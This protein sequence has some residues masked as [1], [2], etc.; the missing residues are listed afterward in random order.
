[1]SDENDGPE[2]LRGYEIGYRRPPK[3]TRFKPGQS[4]NKKGRPRKK[5][6]V[7]QMIE[8][9]LAKLIQ[10]DENGR[11]RLMTAEEII[12]SKL[13]NDAMKGDLR[14]IRMLFDMRDRYQNSLETEIDPAALKDDQDILNEYLLRAKDGFG[15]C[16]AADVEGGHETELRS[17]ENRSAGR[18]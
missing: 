11:R 5:T 8:N 3:H 6:P 7:G 12:V 15:E 9:A 14:A 2:P 1:M 18:Q 16:Q 13:R 17:D 4:G 10:V